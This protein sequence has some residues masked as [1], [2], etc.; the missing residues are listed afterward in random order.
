M[1]Y[2]T[3]PLYGPAIRPIR[4]SSVFI[5]FV[6]WTAPLCDQ[7][8]LPIIGYSVFT[9]SVC[10]LGLIMFLVPLNI[11]LEEEEVHSMGSTDS[12]PHIFYFGIVMSFRDPIILAVPVCTIK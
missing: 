11:V 2:W 12:P 7:A 9:F 4:G 1:E 6:G 3:T 5:F 8:V 10:F